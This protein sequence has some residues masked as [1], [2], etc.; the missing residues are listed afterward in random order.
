MIC[1]ECDSTNHR[2]VFTRQTDDDK[3]MRRK[4]CRDCDHG[5]YSLEIILPPDAVAHLT[6]TTGKTVGL[7]KGY[8]N[9]LLQ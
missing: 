6:E 3:V 5:W 8:R 2:T 7:A 1:P 9:V 4:K